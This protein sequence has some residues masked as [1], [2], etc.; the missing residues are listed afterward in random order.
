MV[1]GRS[2]AHRGWIFMR[3][4][5]ASTLSAP[6]RP[7]VP[8]GLWALTPPALRLIWHLRDGRGLIGI[9]STHREAYVR[10]ISLV[11]YGTPFTSSDVERFGMTLEGIVPAAP[12]FRQLIRSR[13]L[14][15]RAIAAPN[16]SSA[17]ATKRHA[18]GAALS[19]AHSSPQRTPRIANRR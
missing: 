10:N 16:T 5:A 9:D 7:C 12:W 2:L 17:L 4:S 13:W 11:P 18:F 3:C 1:T 19:A 14:S 6:L 8:H 15:C